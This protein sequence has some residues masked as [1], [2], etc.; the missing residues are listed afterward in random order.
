MRSS[1]ISTQR[2]LYTHCDAHCIGAVCPLSVL[3]RSLQCSVQ[4]SLNVTAACVHY[5]VCALCHVLKWLTVSTSQREAPE[6]LAQPRRPAGSTAAISSGRGGR[7]GSST[8][9]GR[10]RGASGKGHGRGRGR[11]RSASARCSV[12]GLQ[13]IMVHRAQL[14]YCSSI[15]VAFGRALPTSCLT[16]G[17]SVRS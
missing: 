15:Q 16:S 12:E 13:Y 17:L 11:G 3:Q 5:T 2:R 7:G 10:G 6:Y 8:A 14:H 4:L 1:T 9:R